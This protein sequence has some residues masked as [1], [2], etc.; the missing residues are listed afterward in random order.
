M[1]SNPSTHAH[2]PLALHRCVDRHVFEVLSHDLVS[3]CMG[4]LVDASAMISARKGSI[5]GQLFLIKHLLI[6]REHIAPFGTNFAIREKN[7][8]FNRLKDAAFGLLHKG[9]KLFALNGSNALIEF[10]LEA[11]Q[12]TEN[13]TDA[14]KDVDVQ[15][16]TVCERFIADVSKSMISPLTS[17]LA[18]ASAF[19]RVKAASK[20]SD[21]SP[22][23]IKLQPFAHPDKVKQVVNE[24]HMLLR[25]QSTATFRSLALYLGNRDTECV[26]FRPI[27]ASIVESYQQLVSLLDAEYTPEDREIIGC[28]AIEHIRLMLAPP[29]S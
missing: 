4:T 19:A 14:K 28:P 20:P 3:T 8:D 18:K 6:L 16:K 25:A 9:N 26:L 21:A 1:V 13:Y 12:V 24:T 11:P 29:T 2:D 5:D 10:L 23:S 17:F 7:L 27:A 15:L 22:P